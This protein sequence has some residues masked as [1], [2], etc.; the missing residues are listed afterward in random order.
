MDAIPETYKQASH[1]MKL[2]KR[3]GDVAMYASLGGDYWEV[4][5]VTVRKAEMTFGKPYPERE[6]LAGNEKFGELAWACTSQERADARFAEA[7]AS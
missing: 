2:V 1:V 3:V 4:H 7:S 5:K 6:V